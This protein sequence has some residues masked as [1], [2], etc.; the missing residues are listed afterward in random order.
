VRRRGGREGI[1]LLCLAFARTCFGAGDMAQTMEMDDAA[2]LGKVW[3]DQLE[4][5]SAAQPNEIAWQAEGWY[6]DDYNKA[7]LRSEGAALSGSTQDARA[8]LFWDHIVTRWWSLEAGAREDFSAGPARGWAALGVRGLAPQGVDVEATVYAGGAARTAARLKI[9]YELLFTQRLV[10]QP[11][12]EMNL[13]GNADPA[14]DVSAAVSD[15]EIGLRL[16][17]EVRREIAP[18]AGVVWVKR[19]G[20]REGSVSAAGADADEIRI[21]VGV[22]LWL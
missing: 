5:R 13:Y 9:E 6:G 11:E 1:A 2:R 19:R 3:L 4:W 22:R 10:L 12:F 7:W 8:E 21:A 15:L 20:A 16:R 14:R 17:Y 18:Y